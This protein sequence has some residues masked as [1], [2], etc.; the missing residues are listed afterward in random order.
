MTAQQELTPIVGTIG[1]NK[2]LNWNG[3]KIVVGHG[4]STFILDEIQYRRRKVK[5]NMMIVVGPPGEGKSYFALRLAQILDPKFNPYEQIVFER[6][7]LL[8]LIGMNSPLKMGQVIVIDEAQFIAGA[9]RWYEDVQKDVMEHIESIRSKGFI[10]IIVALHLNLL[11]KIIRKYVL[12]H[13]ML[14]MERGKAVVYNLWTPPFADKLFR[15]RLGKMALQLPDYELCAYSSCL[16]CRF[17]DKCNTLRAIYER[18]KSEFLG[19]MSEQ[20]QQKAAA[21]E[22]RKKIINYKDMLNKLIEHKDEMVFSKSGT[23]EPESVRLILEEKYGVALA[24]AEARR[25]IKRGE[26]KHPEVFKQE[27]VA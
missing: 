1:H 20:S 5:Q 12:S 23:V 21:R 17:L 16:T 4:K 6:T 27:K 26:I 14:M 24:D 25:I 7:H 2:I 13:M 22:K 19:R 11:D 9:R 18:L 8:Q 15:R 10:V 3:Y